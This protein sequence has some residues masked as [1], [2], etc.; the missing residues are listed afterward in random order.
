[1]AKVMGLFKQK[2]LLSEQIA[3]NRDKM[4]IEAQN[5]GVKYVLG[6]HREDI[7]SLVYNTFFKKQVKKDF[8]ALKEV[9]FTGYS[10]DILGVIGSNGAG[11]TTLCRVVSGLLSPDKGE[12][13]INGKVSSLLSLSAGFN[14]QLSGEENIYINGMMLGLSKRECDELLPEI[15]RFSGL[16]RFIKQ[17]V[18]HYSSGMKSRLG[19]SIA[20]MLEPEILVVDEALSV[21]DLEFSEKAANKM[22]EIVGSANMVIVVTHQVDFVLKYCNR[23][24]WIDKGSVMAN[25]SPEEVVKLYKES[26]KET[27]KAKKIVSLNETR[28]QIGDSKAVDVK[29][30]GISFSIFDTNWSESDKKKILT[31]FLHKRKKQF[32][33]LKDVSFTVNEGDIVGIIGPNGSG[34]TTLCRVLSGILR[35]DTGS[36]F[37]NGE[38]TALL[39]IGT[40]FNGRLSG[41]DNIYLNGMMLG[42]PKKKLETIYNDI[43]EF[44][45]LHKFIDKPVKYYSSGMKA[46]LGFSIAAMIQPD[47]FI[48]DEALSVGD[49]SFYETAS[50]KI[51]EIIGNSKAVI[52]V[53]HNLG[54]VEKVCTRALWLGRGTITFEGDPQETVMRYRQSLKK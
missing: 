53:T 13:K 46:R 18:K 36:V 38:T 30:L 22:R 19:F 11:K 14:N 23:A 39:A 12:I 6:S 1:V 47:V 37:I 8:W 25:G 48:I 42:I 2:A 43:V 31:K 41:R 3:N 7:Q 24:L 45:G 32:W 54:F 21:G 29:N 26:I 40:G 28:P 17:P 33:A 35:A 49:A 5:L 10:G 50:A 34:K 52:V 44:S 51:Q 16:E 27:P 9:S 4:L 15:I 20:V